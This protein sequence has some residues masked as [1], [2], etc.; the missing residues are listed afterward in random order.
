M[1][2]T[3]KYVNHSI[4]RLQVYVGHLVKEVWCKAD[5]D[6]SLDLLHLDLQEIVKDIFN[7]EENTTRSKM[8]DWLYGPI[9]KIYELFKGIDPNQR[10]Q[11]ADWYELNND[12]EALCDDCDPDKAPASYLD[13]RAINAGPAVRWYRRSR[14]S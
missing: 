1:H 10:Q 7:T 8:K 14:G 3:Y 13:V 12:I 4:E 6:F 2:F 9:V 5:G 11:I